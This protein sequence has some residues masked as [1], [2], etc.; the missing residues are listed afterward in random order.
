MADFSDENFRPA[1]PLNFET[2]LTP[3]EDNAGEAEGSVELT[4][5]PVFMDVSGDKSTYN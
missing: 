2:R 3:E 4:R 1:G 5:V